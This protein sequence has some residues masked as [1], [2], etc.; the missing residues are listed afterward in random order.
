MYNT[1]SSGNNPLIDMLVD[2]LKTFFRSEFIHETG[3]GLDFNF[4][5]KCILL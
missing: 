3:A 5:M 2:S 4:I 1:A